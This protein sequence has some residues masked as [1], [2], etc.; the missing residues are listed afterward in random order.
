MGCTD[1]VRMADKTVCN[2]A[3]EAKIKS[4][5]RQACDRDGGRGR[6]FDTRRQRHVRSDLPAPHI[7][8]DNS[9]SSFSDV[10]NDVE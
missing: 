10:E 8:I 2:P 4:W 3:V 1:A 7:P 5:L 9:S 6:R